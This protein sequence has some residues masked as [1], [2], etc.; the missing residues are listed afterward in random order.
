MPW[1]AHLRAFGGITVR[2]PGDAPRTFKNST[3]LAQWHTEQK[4]EE[5]SSKRRSKK[6]EKKKNATEQGKGPTPKK[7]DD[8]NCELRD[9]PTSAPDE[10]PSVSKTGKAVV[11]E[12][13]VEEAIPVE[14][15]DIDEDELERLFLSAPDEITW[16]S[17]KP[18]DG[19]DG[20]A[21]GQQARSNV[22]AAPG[23]VVSIPDSG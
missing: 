6:T 13:A 2:P 5:K 22:Q 15:D 18:H 14:E 19:D 11:G 16:E 21:P 12:K 23:K 9:T 10:I 3:E 8:E 7:K 20:K 1:D 4:L 17:E